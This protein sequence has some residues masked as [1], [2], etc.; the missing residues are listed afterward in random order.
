MQQNATLQH[1][2]APGW[3][4]AMQGSDAAHAATQMLLQLAARADVETSA[5][6]VLEAAIDTLRGHENAAL[7]IATHHRDF[8]EAIPDAITVHDMHGDVLDAN[9]AACRLYGHAREVLL[10]LNLH[11]LFPVLPPDHLRQVIAVCQS[12]QDFTIETTI[13]HAAGRDF[14]V[15][16][17]SSVYLDGAEMRVLSIAR[18]IGH[19]QRTAMALRD[20]EQRYRVTLHSMDKGV[21]I[22]DRNGRML[23]GNPAAYRIFQLSETDAGQLEREGFPG[24]HYADAFGN[25]ITQDEL[26]FARAQRS[27]KAVES[28]LICFWMPHLKHPLWL[29]A[30]AVPLFRDDGGPLYQVVS[31]F[32]DVTELKRTRDVLE[33]TQAIASIGGYEI[34]VGT[35]ELIWTRE[36]YRLFDLPDDIPISLDRALALL[37]PSSRDRAVLDIAEARRGIHIRREYEIVTALGRR[38]WISAAYRPV[39]NGGS[40]YSISGTCQDITERKLLE[41][42]LRHKLVTDPVTGL[43]NRAQIIEELDR[44]I[45]AT[46]GS[47]GPSLLYIDLDRFKIINDVLGAAAGDTLLAS[48]A[49]RL[50]EC[51]PDGA[52]C[53]RFAGDEFLVLLPRSMHDEQPG[54]IAEIINGKFRR[55]F[56]YAGEEFVITA[57]I[58]LARYP[59]G[60]TNAQ[61]LLHHAD[62]AM[63]EAKHR[64]RGTWQAFSPAMARRLE[65]NLAIANQLRSALANRELRLVYQPQ[66][67]LANGNVV[68]VEALLRWD[69]PQRGELHPMAFVQHAES[70]GEIVAIGAWAID[71][72]CRQLRAWRAEGLALERV[73]VNVS[74][75]QLLSEAFLETVLATLR[76]YELPGESLELEMIER[77]LIEDTPD[78]VQMFKDLREAGVTI[79]I[80]DFGEGYSALNYLRRLPIDGFKISYDFMRRVPSS[81]PDTAI[82]EAIIRVGHG[83]GL[84]MVAE[85][86]ETEQQRSFLLGQGMRFGQG[87]LFSPAL[88]ARGIAAFAR[89]RGVAPQP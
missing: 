16:V 15:E 4:H 10:A 59:D 74:Y 67:E 80:D 57:S 13:R 50:Q 7:A 77:M 87:H 33:Q 61:Q 73:A 31:T 58:G 14:P 82:C 39:F 84:S 71:E 35:D 30:T 54:E 88:D 6:E 86:V 51:L 52:R 17:H 46:R 36:M 60:G 22:R 75:R 9:A 43:V 5:R 89:A 72:A 40:V 62:A 78:T 12:K 25:A 81:T 23:Y 18:G 24:W 41:F 29:S 66:V 79:T 47:S 83:L 68:A 20:A 49:R 56:E 53:G 55:P 3:T 63:S 38:R 11:D 42:E 45:I 21:I 19:W 85:G 64:G 28:E 34:I 44:Q 32:T 8:I 1:T 2:D 69:H 70:S 26:P 65:N 48:A 37:D 76:K 27:G